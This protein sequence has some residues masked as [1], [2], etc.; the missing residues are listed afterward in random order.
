MLIAGFKLF[1]ASVFALAFAAGGTLAASIAERVMDDA[2][3]VLTV[4]AVAFALGGVV[5][6][7]LVS[8]QHPPVRVFFAGAVAGVLLAAMLHTS[9]GYNA[10]PSD[11]GVPL[12]VLAAVLGPP[13]GVL[14]VRL[15]KSALVIST[16][17]SGAS[18]LVWGV[19]YFASN[20]PSAADLGRYHQR[21]AHSGEL[22]TGY[23][24]P[25]ARWIYHGVTL[26]LALA[27]VL[28]QTKLTARGIDRI[29][30]GDNTVDLLQDGT[31]TPAVATGGVS[32]RKV[33]VLARYDHVLDMELETPNTSDVRSGYA[34]TGQRAR[35]ERRS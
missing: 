12:L 26:V 11:P 8:I 27:G 9:V 31:G 24:I 5:S 23:A 29:D 4:S 1:Q 22:G 14:A 2:S 30:G 19:G 21:D 28:L 35:D 33:V 3:N 25:S 34:D 16:S 10:C 20:Y 7:V 13:C 18:L 6:G 17:F 32:R 15:E